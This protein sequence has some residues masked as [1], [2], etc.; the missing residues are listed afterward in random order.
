MKCIDCEYV[1]EDGCH[2]GL[3]PS[4]RNRN[5]KVNCRYYKSIWRRHTE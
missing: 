2:K 5:E 4:D 3:S 1:K